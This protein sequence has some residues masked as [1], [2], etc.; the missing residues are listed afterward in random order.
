MKNK[1]KSSETLLLFS[2]AN[3]IK[4]YCNHTRLIMGLEI[5]NEVN[6]PVMPLNKST[7]SYWRRILFILRKFYQPAT[8]LVASNQ[9]K[10]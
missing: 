6:E 10:W 1:N 5:N 4:T 7:L 9:V 8:T 2:D 3:N